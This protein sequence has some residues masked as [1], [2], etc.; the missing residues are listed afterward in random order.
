MNL[1]TSH[2]NF[3]EIFA[4]LRFFIKNLIVVLPVILN[5]TIITKIYTLIYMNQERNFA[6]YQE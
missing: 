6:Q 4:I 1:N 5:I 3:I 2:S